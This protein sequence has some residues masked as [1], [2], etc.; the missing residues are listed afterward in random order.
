MWGSDCDDYVGDFYDPTHQCPDFSGSAYCNSSMLCNDDGYMY[1]CDWD[2]DRFSCAPGDL[3]GKFG[4]MN[5][6][7][8]ITAFGLAMTSDASMGTLIPPLD[9]IQD[10]VFVAYCG[11]N[12]EGI[13]NFACAPFDVTSTTTTPTEAETTSS[14]SDDEDHT[15]VA[16]FTGHNGIVGNVT[17]DN[18]HVII[19]LDL[20]DEPTDVISTGNFTE[21]IAGG[22]KYHIHESWGHSYASFDQIGSTACGSS[23]T[24]GHWDPWHGM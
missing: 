16:T 20:S 14:D 23:Y 22:L 3:S 12:S 21:C 24:A 19:G 2:N 17:I 7:G 13:T 5:A 8:G 6:S 4:S 1:D 15:F 18:G 9:D 10:M 11:S